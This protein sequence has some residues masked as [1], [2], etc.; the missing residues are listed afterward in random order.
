LLAFLDR[1]FPKAPDDLRGEA[2][3]EALVG[4]LSHPD[5]YDPTR[6]GLGAYLRMAARGDMK[7][8]LAREA[9]HRRGIPL[10]SVEEPVDDRNSECDDEPTW[11]H[12]ALAAE[13]AALEPPE[14]ITFELIRAGVRDTAT[15]VRRLALT[16]LS[17]EEQNRTVKRLK[18]RVRKRLSRAAEDCR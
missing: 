13:T 8:L 4:F 10:D 12:P 16:H 9:R 2:A 11:D 18:D 3:N 7:N 6:C 14:R 17:A 5:R 1:A 15:F